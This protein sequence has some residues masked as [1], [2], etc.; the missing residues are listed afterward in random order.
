MKKC[1]IELK[2]FIYPASQQIHLNKI[3]IY[4]YYLWMFT[5]QNCNISSAYVW[6]QNLRQATR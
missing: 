1:N 2:M 6:I 3:I 5:I 4:L